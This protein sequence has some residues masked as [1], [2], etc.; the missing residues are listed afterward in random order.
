[1][2]D[3]LVI[4][5]FDALVEQV[6]WSIVKPCILSMAGYFPHVEYEPL[7]NHIIDRIVKQ[8]ELDVN[9]CPYYNSNLAYLIPREKSRVWGWFV[10]YIALAYF[11]NIYTTNIS[12]KQMRT[13]LMYYRRLITSLRKNVVVKFVPETGILEAENTPL[14]EDWN[15][16]VTVVNKPKYGGGHDILTRIRGTPPTTPTRGTPSTRGTPPTTPTGTP[17]VENIPLT[18]VPVG[19]VGGTPLVENIPLVKNIPLTEVTVGGNPITDVPVGVVGGIPLVGVV[20]GIPLVEGTPLVEGNTPPNS[21][22]RSWL[23]WA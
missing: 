6:G 23:G 2:L 4:E 14:P 12:A 15:D 7:F 1:M 9:E 20:G 11:P 19:V 21:S 13:R 10:R 5:A 22:W 18:D 17:L 16:L 8:L 3:Y